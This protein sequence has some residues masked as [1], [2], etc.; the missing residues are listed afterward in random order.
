M[1]SFYDDITLKRISA[2]T[3]RTLDPEGHTFFN[4]N[5][6]DELAQAEEILTKQ[7]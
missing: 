3:I 4:V 2:D 6:P 5:T 1:V 7:T